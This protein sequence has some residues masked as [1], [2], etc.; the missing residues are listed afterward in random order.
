MYFSIFQ[1]FDKY[2]PCCHAFSVNAENT[3][4]MALTLHFL[5]AWDIYI[6]QKAYYY[7]FNTLNGKIKYLII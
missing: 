4:I 7:K 6:T 2:I 1:Y 3:P 5:A